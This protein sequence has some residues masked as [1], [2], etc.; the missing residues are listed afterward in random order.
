MPKVMPITF[1]IVRIEPDHGHD[2]P[3]FDA[4]VL[5]D[6]HLADD[7]AVHGGHVVSADPEGLQLYVVPHLAGF[8]L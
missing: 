8:Q 4:T 3:P 7:A 6:G 2:E 5:G 1:G